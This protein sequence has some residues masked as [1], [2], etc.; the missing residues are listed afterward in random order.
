[1]QTDDLYV[2]NFPSFSEGFEPR[3]VED[4]YH[5]RKMFSIFNGI[6]STYECNRPELILPIRELQASFM[7][8]NIHSNFV[9]R[10]IIRRTPRQ[11]TSWFNTPYSVDRDSSS[12]RKYDFKRLYLALSP[13]KSDILGEMSP[14]NSGSD[15]NVKNAA[16]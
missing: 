13:Q 10:L 1:M 6:V 4:V 7:W 16:K 11:S 9:V 15:A 5:P 2:A 3:E 12:P 14:S 8:Y